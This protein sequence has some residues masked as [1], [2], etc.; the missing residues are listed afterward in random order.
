MTEENYK[1]GEITNPAYQRMLRPSCIND[2]ISY[3]E[4]MVK[5]YFS[6]IVKI[7]T[8]VFKDKFRAEISTSIQMMF[9]KAKMFLKL[10]EGSSHTDGTYKTILYY[11]QSLERHTSNFVLLKLF[12]F[13]PILKR[14]E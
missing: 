10:L 13:C 4:L 8:H 7:G 3:L 14:N 11:L 1:T 9:T 5:F 2:R 12:M 6:A